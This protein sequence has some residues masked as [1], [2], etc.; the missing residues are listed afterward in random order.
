[1]NQILN[2]NPLKKILLEIKRQYE[3]SILVHIHHIH[4]VYL[5]AIQQWKWGDSEIL[6]N[7][8]PG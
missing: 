5:H 6:M 3:T 7:E 8:I 4:F 1:M 2:F